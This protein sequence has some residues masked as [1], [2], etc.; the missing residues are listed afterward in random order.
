PEL[1]VLLQQ[2]RKRK[3]RELHTLEVVDFITQRNYGIYFDI[4]AEERMLAAGLEAYDEFK[5]D[6]VERLGQRLKARGAGKKAS[7]PAD[8]ETLAETADLLQEM[9][10]HSARF[11]LLL[12]D[13]L[14]SLGMTV[15]K[16]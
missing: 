9:D 4:V 10:E 12:G 2:V 13:V 5:T 1:Q 11:N 16:R 3:D 7:L 14:A 8:W 15:R 6:C